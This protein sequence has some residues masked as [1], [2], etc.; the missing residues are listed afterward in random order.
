MNGLDLAR[1]ARLEPRQIPDLDCFNECTGVDGSIMTQA[2][3]MFCW[4]YQDVAL[5][6]SGLNG[7]NISVSNTE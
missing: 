4:Q 2:I 1:S 6:E 3:S 5:S 7:Y